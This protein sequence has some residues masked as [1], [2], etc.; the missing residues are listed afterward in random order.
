MKR[1]V[2]TSPSDSDLRVEFKV[3][4]LDGHFQVLDISGKDAVAVQLGID[5]NILDYHV[6]AFKT[7]AEDNNLSL[8]AY[9]IDGAPVQLVVSTTTTTTSTTT[10]T[11]T[12]TTL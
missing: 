6:A 7:F 4:R 1:L 5:F 9:D 11:T 10:T 8:D 2:F 12:T 3:D